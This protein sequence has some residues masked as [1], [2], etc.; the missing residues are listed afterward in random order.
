MQVDSALRRSND[1]IPALDGWRAIAI[2]MVL[3][4]HG[5]PLSDRLP[6]DLGA[7]GVAFFFILSGYLI[8]TRLL[9]K[10]YDGGKVALGRFYVQR[11]FRILPPAICYLVFL[12]LLNQMVRGLNVSRS[13]IVASLFFWRNYLLVPHSAEKLTGW[14]TGH[15]WSL[16]VEEHYYLVWPLIIH[17]AGKKRALRVALI[18]AAG[19]ALWRWAGWHYKFHINYVFDHVPYFFR[20]DTRLDGL[21]LGSAVAIVLN[22]PRAAAAIRQYL[23]VRES[24]ACIVLLGITWFF[25]GF[26]FIGFKEELIATV[27]LLA[28]LSRPS[29]GLA[30]VLAWPPLRMIGRFSYSLYIWQ[31]LFLVVQTGRTPLGRLNQFP[32]NFVL[33]FAAALASYYFVE[34]PA[35]RFGAKFE[36]GRETTRRAELAAV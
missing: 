31:Q 8:T 17:Q 33:V 36:V 5:S 28:T 25:A 27:L 2:L 10:Y 9:T 16:S 13:E 29:E 23:S 26:P 32:L 21:L 20:T 35:R 11:G 12:F 15:F 19:C 6:V 1:Y 24:A 34:G 22:Y 14:F 30:R 7:S 4:A 3:F 18:G